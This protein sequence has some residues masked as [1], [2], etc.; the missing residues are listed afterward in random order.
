MKYIRLEDNYVDLNIMIAIYS[1]PK[2]F[3][4]VNYTHE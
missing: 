3:R 4:Y 1:T 2:F